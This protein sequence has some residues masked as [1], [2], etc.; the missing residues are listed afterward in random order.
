[1]CYGA[2]ATRTIFMRREEN[3]RPVE[4]EDETV[5]ARGPVRRIFL[6]PMHCTVI[7]HEFTRNTATACREQPSVIWSYCLLPLAAGRIFGGA[8]SSVRR[9]LGERNMEGSVC[10]RLP[11][12]VGVGQLR[13]NLKWGKQ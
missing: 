13:A 5:L 12:I 6:A 1:M 9:S 3:G 7:F 4:Y 11:R 10:I 2:V 8:D